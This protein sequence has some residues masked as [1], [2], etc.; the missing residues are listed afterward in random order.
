MREHEVK[1][2]QA[3]H[4]LAKGN[5]GLE[6][7]REMRKREGMWKGAGRVAVPNHRPSAVWRDAG[8]PCDQQNNRYPGH[9]PCVIIAK[10]RFP[11]CNIPHHTGLSDIKNEM[12]N[13]KKT[14]KQKN[15]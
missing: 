13:V 14:K 4:G 10:L 2:E 1:G 12:R 5:S 6:R 7:L 8:K 11:I 9:K 15:T 3:P